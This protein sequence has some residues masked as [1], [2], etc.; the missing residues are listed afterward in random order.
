[1]RFKK[2]TSRFN[3]WV[4]D[5]D[6]IHFYLTEVNSGDEVRVSLDPEG[7][8]KLIQELSEVLEA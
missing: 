1:M 4:Q 2:D 8:K 7:A 3:L 5:E 6:V